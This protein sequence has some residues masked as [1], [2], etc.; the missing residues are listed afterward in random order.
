MAHT[1]WRYPPKEVGV[2]RAAR[3]LR[4]CQRRESPFTHWGTAPS[5]RREKA[6]TGRP[7]VS[8]PTL[9][10]LK[11]EMGSSSAVEVLGPASWAGGLPP[12]RL[13]PGQWASLPLLFWGAWAPSPGRVA[14]AT[15]VEG[16]LP[17]AAGPD[18]AG[19]VVSVWGGLEPR[20]WPRMWAT[21]LPPWAVGWSLS[22]SRTS[23]LSIVGNPLKGLLPAGE[24]L[25][26]SWGG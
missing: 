1:Q 2:L 17:R 26:V 6:Y 15:P 20:T 12:P 11:A 25:C 14:V 23:P 13:Q 3:G 9:L 19:S 24:G 5:M 18:R 16:E 22:A 4:R 10:L 8:F 7:S 21:L